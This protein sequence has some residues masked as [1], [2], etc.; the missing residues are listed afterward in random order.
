MCSQ[1]SRTRRLLAAPRSEHM[2]VT[3][4]RYYAV[5]II[6]STFSCI[7]GGAT[8]LRY[9]ARCRAGCTG[10][11]RG[12]GYCDRACDVAACFYDYNPLTGIMD[13]SALG[14][15]LIRFDMIFCTLM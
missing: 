1:A 10:A 2:S 5:G 11:M 13:C 14:F 3:L 15:D 7:F 9:Y 8:P 4:V 6:L 12:D